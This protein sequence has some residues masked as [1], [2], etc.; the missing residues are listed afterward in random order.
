MTA[1]VLILFVEDEPLISELMQV[2][3]ED[4]GF[5]IEVGE[6][7]AEAISLFDAR[8]AEIAALLTDVRLGAGPSGWDVARHARH[9]KP[10]LPVG[11]MTGDSAA[12]WA[13]EGVPKSVLLQKPFA[14]AQA[15]T[16]LATL[17]N[18][19]SSNLSTT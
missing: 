14:P 18:E 7:G 1:I 13:A 16:A 8:S 11:Y 12:D 9:A 19:V 3:L 10:D 15:V 5:S 6:S 2:S 4:A 17:L